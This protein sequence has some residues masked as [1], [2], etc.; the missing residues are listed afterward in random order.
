MAPIRVT[1][2]VKIR[3]DAKKLIPSIRGKEGVATGVFGEKSPFAYM[4]QL[5]N[6]PEVLVSGDELHG[7]YEICHICG[8][9]IHSPISSD[10]ERCVICLNPTCHD[11]ESKVWGVCE[12]CYERTVE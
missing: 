5:N 10:D 4:V 12:L 1:Q 3:D 7:I 9:P 11:C 6:G 2:R 8:K